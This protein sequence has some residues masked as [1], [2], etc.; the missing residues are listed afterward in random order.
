M[1]NA[2]N[3][4]MNFPRRDARD[5]LSGRTRYTIDR[6]RPGMLHATLLRA[7][8]ASARVVRVDTSIARKMPGVRAIVTAADAPALHG[9]EIADHPLF[10]SDRIRYVGEPIA[11]VAAE[12]A[13]K[14]AAAAAAIVVEREPLP[15]V[16]TMADALAPNAPWV[17]PDW[18]D[19]EVLFE[20]GAR[21]GNVAWEATVSRGDVNAAFA[22][23]DVTIVESRFRVGR[24]N[25][26]SFEPRAVVAEYEDGRFHI[27][28]STQVPW[29]I[30]NTV[31]RL[32]NVPP[33]SVRVTVPAV[34]G[35]FGFGSTA[36]S[37]PTRRCSRERPAGR[38]ASSIRG[39]RR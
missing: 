5:K 24:P 33:S 39:R 12:T 32:L 13:A 23:E 37:N 22:R 19:Y 1:S 35:G 4:V 25:H 10:A 17:H 27:E 7:D 16:V 36:R 15:A 31:A 26:L 21:A 28:T 38:F 3:A 30:R 14:A 18:R 9:I 34:G 20:G 29:T 2:T 6:A 8:T 11:A